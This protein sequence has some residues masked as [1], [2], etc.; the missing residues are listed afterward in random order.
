M[1]VKILATLGALVIG[2]SAVA[3]NYGEWF[4]KVDTNA[5]GYLSAEELGEKKAHKIDKID[6]DGDRLI[7]RKELEAY[8]AEKHR[9][10]DEK[11]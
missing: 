6:T 3:G 8:K 10:K 11:A 5:D 9:K 7:S 1:K 2:T 4:E